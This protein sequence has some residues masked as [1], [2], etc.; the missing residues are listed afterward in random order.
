MADITKA[1][2][3]LID[4]VLSGEGRASRELRRAAFDNRDIPEALRPLIDKIARNAYKVVDDDIAAAKAAGF[5]ED[6]LFELAVCAAIGQASR[7]HD[8]AL[9]ALASATE[10]A[11]KTKAAT[12]E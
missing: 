8:S 4:R 3:V 1:R 10:A 12:K 6:Q 9:A 7:Q 11:I 2:Q 5:S